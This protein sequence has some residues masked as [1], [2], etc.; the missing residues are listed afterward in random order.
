MYPFIEI[1]ELKIQTYFI[2]MIGI[3]CLSLIL[4]YRKS[5]KHSINK[6]FLL[7][8]TLLLAFS[9]FF[10]ARLTH[11]VFENFL[12]Y[13]LNPVEVIK[14]WNGGFVFLGGFLGAFLTG[15]IFVFVNKKKEFIPE[16]MD[17]YAPILALV[18]SLGRIGCFL[19]GC[20]YG[21]YCEL[22]WSI[23]G[24]HPTQLYAFL[25]DGCLFV[26]LF[27]L[28]RA[29]TRPKSWSSGTLFSV[30]ML[31]HGIGRFWQEFFRDDFRGPTFIFTLS[32]WLSLLLIIS[33][34]IG[35]IKFQKS[36]V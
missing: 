8:L 19:A 3:F 29:K 20:C 33:G 27:F 26:L 21:K 2:V 6:Q 16:L 9:G 11:V 5:K 10:F 35:F 15:F 18:Y 7:D 32:G 28:E 36:K 31:G 34:I 13:Y 12:Y 22:S 1:F 24:R 4:V 30:W 17:F 14:F 25:W 23:K